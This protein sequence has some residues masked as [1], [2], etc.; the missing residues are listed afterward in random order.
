MTFKTIGEINSKLFNSGKQRENS[1]W[2]IK[3]K[4]ND[5]EISS[6]QRQILS[7]NG[8][9]RYVQSTANRLRST[10][11]KFS[12]LKLYLKALDKTAGKGTK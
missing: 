4:A 7:K 9:Q 1:F 11:S 2:Y 6:K 12:D 3:K 5:E 8:S 10:S